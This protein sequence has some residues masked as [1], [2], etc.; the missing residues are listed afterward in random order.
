ME[1]EVY[2]TRRAQRDL[3]EA[4][5]FIAQFAPE[6]AER[7]YVDFLRAL[8]SLEKNPHVHP[9][10]AESKDLPFELRQFIYR[11]RSKRI[12]RAL[13]IISGNQVRV[14]AVRRPGQQAV[15]P[16]DLE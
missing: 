7:W 8:C 14:L 9:V 15:R 4:R 11:T 5:D 3:N 13:F 6:T 16:E 1:F 10:A 2:V 12:N